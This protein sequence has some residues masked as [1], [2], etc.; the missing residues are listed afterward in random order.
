ML[1]NG[2]Q[3]SKHRLPR[4]HMWGS[5]RGPG[6]GRRSSSGL[7]LWWGRE[8]TP[9]TTSFKPVPSPSSHSMCFSPAPTTKSYNLALCGR[10]FHPT[11]RLGWW[12]AVKEFSFVSLVPCLSSFQG[13][14]ARRSGA[15][16]V[17]TEHFSYSAALHLFFP[18]F[19]VWPLI[20]CSPSSTQ[21]GVSVTFPPPPCLSPKEGFQPA[22]SALG[23][24]AGRW[25]E[26][27]EGRDESRGRTETSHALVLW[28]NLGT[29]GVQKE[30]LGKL[31]CAKDVEKQSGGESI[32]SVKHAVC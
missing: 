7:V 3:M 6:R 9:W 28:A 14:W 1:P 10:S 5:F 31:L 22:V 21:G 30:S 24:S 15:E 18:G 4:G 32:V 19:R 11:H 27:R 16:H 20:L 12:L 23:P 8:F 2:H 13:T 26:V 29:A 17:A 25:G